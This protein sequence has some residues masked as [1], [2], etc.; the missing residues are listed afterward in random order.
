MATIGG[1]HN[2][3][4]SIIDGNSVTFL[5]KVIP[6]VRKPPPHQIA[7]VP[8]SGGGP[9]RSSH[10]TRIATAMTTPVVDGVSVFG[11]TTA[12]LMY[13]MNTMSSL[14]RFNATPV[15][16][17]GERMRKTTIPFIHSLGV[18]PQGLPMLQRR[19]MSLLSADRYQCGNAFRIT[20]R[21]IETLMN[22]A[23]IVYAPRL[24]PGSTGIFRGDTL[25]QSAWE[26]QEYRRSQL[27]AVSGPVYCMYDV[28]CNSIV[29]ATRTFHVVSIPGIN[30]EYAPQDM[31]YY[32]QDRMYRSDRADPRMRDIWRIILWSFREAGVN[33]P[34]LCAIGCGAFAGNSVL[35]VPRHCAEALDHVLRETTWG[36]DVVLVSV[37]GS[38]HDPFRDALQR[39]PGAGAGGF[40]C[41][42]IV[43]KSHGVLELAHEITAAHPLLVCGV[44]NPSDVQAVR[45]G[46][47]GMF[48]NRGH[49]ALE[50]ILALRTTLLLQHV[51]LNPQ[52]W[53]DPT[54]R[55]PC[56]VPG[57]ESDHD[58]IP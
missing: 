20:K 58:T 41:P 7:P 27:V 39:Q 29:K 17:Q 38:N 31:R 28:G 24:F 21:E 19:G 36:F 11:P 51:S 1:F 12:T 40:R 53:T 34:I 55:I 16:D 5:P 26:D 13:V 25:K 6:W 42:V 15:T 37:P 49:V 3:W 35:Q 8:A 43:T 44:L 9:S 52:L 50:E 46:F 14:P 32:A 45:Q 30:F 56:T 48:W 2:A 22:A 4:L 33:V 54:R 18:V 23:V 57:L 47:I 10:R